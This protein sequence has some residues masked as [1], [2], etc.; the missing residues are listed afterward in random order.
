MQKKKGPGFEC[1]GEYL[2][3]RDR[4]PRELRMLYEMANELRQKLLRRLQSILEC[5]SYRF[6][7]L[8]IRS[9]ICSREHEKWRTYVATISDSMF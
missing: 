5:K 4:I 9:I 2:R 7:R 3:Y 6:E 8:K 1:D